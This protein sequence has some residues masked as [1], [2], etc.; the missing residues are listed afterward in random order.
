MLRHAKLSICGQPGA[1]VCCRIGPNGRERHRIAENA[2]A[3]TPPRDGAACL[4]TWASVPT[5]CDAS[6]CIPP[7]FVCGNGT[8]EPGESCDPPDLVAC[9]DTCQKIICGP[10]TLCGNGSLDPGEACEPPGTAGCGFDCQLEPCA[11]AA[12]GELAIA[13]VKGP[14]DLSAGSNGTGFLVAWSGP[15]RAGSPE[16][17][18]RRLDADGLPIESP[19]RIVS[20]EEPCGSHRQPAVAS[21]GSAYLVAWL[22]TGGGQVG[23][24]TFVPFQVIHS[25]R[26]LVDGSLA[27][28]DRLALQYSVGQCHSVLDGPTAA[29]GR[30]PGRYGV[31]WENVAACV[32]GPVFHNPGGVLLDFGVDPSMRQPVSLGFPIMAPP[33]V[34]SASSA[35]IAALGADTLAVFH[36][37]AA[38]ESMPPFTLI[39]AVFGAFLDGGGVPS[40]FLLTSRKLASSGRPWVAAGAA[41]FLVAWGQSVTDAIATPTEIRTMRLT[42]LAGGLDPDGGRLLATSLGGAITGGPVVAFD[43]TVWLVAWVEDVSGTSTLRAVA[44]RD[45]GTVVDAMPRTIAS[46]VDPGEPALASLGDGRVL[47]VYRQPDGAATA[48]RA[49]LVPGT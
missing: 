22:T 8:I 31:L 40:Q 2:D 47:V 9:S 35:T 45:D 19:Q 41:S 5:G 29:T 33:G 18:V 20:D 28:T 12:A 37:T 7:A 39:G 36:A 3:C 4:S 14:T 10:P 34:L 26:L 32:S 43:G 24:H 46:G 25:R 6:G 21:D 16:V 38:L 48:V 17:A 1:V 49:R 13:C 23:Q 44:V 27:T 30:G 11:P 42:R 15:L